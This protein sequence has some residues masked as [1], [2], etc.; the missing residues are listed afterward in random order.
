M[1]GWEGLPLW[2]TRRATVVFSSFSTGCGTRHIAQ[3][4]KRNGKDQSLWLLGIRDR[5]L[6]LAAWRKFQVQVSQ[7]P[8]ISFSRTE[9]SVRSFLSRSD[10]LEHFEAFVDYGFNLEAHLLIPELEPSAKSRRKKDRSLANF[11]KGI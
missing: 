2:D 5:K 1:H 11:K 6:A 3:W 9:T 7:N 10:V 4:F 8:A